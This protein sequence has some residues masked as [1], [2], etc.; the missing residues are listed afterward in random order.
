MFADYYAHLYF[1]NPNKQDD[2][3]DDDFDKDAILAEIEAEAE[4]E[5][6]NE[7]DDVTPDDQDSG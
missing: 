5:Q 2:V 7:W 4:A 3:V 6:S 1:D